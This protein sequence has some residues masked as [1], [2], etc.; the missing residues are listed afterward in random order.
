VYEVKIEDYFSGAH[1]LRNYRG[2]CEA[3]HGHNWKVEVLV[4]SDSL[5]EGGMVLDFKILRD[6]TRTVLETLDHKYL[7][8]VPDF[9]DT[10]PSSENI[11]KYVFCRLKPI[12]DGY[13]ATLRKVTVWES[14]KACAS[15]LEDDRDD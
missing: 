13:P 1:R 14:E 5:D 6:S 2:K 3:L 7:N 8:E 15:Y 11:A 12:L 4:V 10:D 9:L